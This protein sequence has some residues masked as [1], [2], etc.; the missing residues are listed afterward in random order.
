MLPSAQRKALRYLTNGLPDEIVESKAAADSVAEAKLV[1][2]DSDAE[3]STT[4]TVEDD[5]E[6]EADERDG[7]WPSDYT[8][9]QWKHKRADQLN[10]I[11][12]WREER[13]RANARKLKL[14]KQASRLAAITAAGGVVAAPTASAEAKTAVADKDKEKEKDDNRFE[15]VRVDMSTETFTILKSVNSANAGK[16]AKPR[17]NARSLTFTPQ[18]FALLRVPPLNEEPAAATS[19]SLYERLYYVT[20]ESR[21]DFFL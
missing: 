18:S 1:R 4:A 21:L 6:A 9:N 7:E 11:R 14:E 2:V 8:C 16:S 20:S 17:E 12:K 15:R 3:P 13:R 10:S 19:P 5:D